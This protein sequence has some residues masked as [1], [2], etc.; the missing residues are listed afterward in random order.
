M[1]KII[2][3]TVLLL[4]SLLLLLGINTNV[5]ANINKLDYGVS[6]EMVDIYFNA[7]SYGEYSDTGYQILYSDNSDIAD[8]LEDYYYSYLDIMPEGIINVDL[9]IK[10]I[11][12]NDLIFPAFHKVTDK[13]ILLHFTYYEF[14]NPS[15]GHIIFYFDSTRIDYNGKIGT[16]AAS[17]WDMKIPKIEYSNT[18][19][20]P[21]TES[22]ELGNVTFSYKD[23]DLTVNIEIDGEY[24]IL[25]RKFKNSADMSIFDTVEAYYMNV[26]DTPQIIIS[27]AE[28]RYLYDILTFPDSVGYRPAFVPHSI[29]DLKTHKLTTQS[30][31]KT[32]VYVKQNKK[33][34]IISY[35]YIDEFVMDKV[36]SAEIRWT[37]REKVSWPASIIK[38][39]YTEWETHQNIFTDEDYLSYKNLTSSW[40]MYM[41]VW[42][43]IRGIYQ[44]TKTFNMKNIDR[45][46][47][48]KP[49]KEYNITRAEL[50]NVF[51]DKNKD[52]ELIK[53]D[54]RYNVF[55]FALQGGKSFMGTQTEFFPGTLPNIDPEDPRHY[56][57]I[58]LKYIT[59]GRLYSTKGDHMEIKIGQS[60]ETDPFEKEKPIITKAIPTIL[61][62]GGVIFVGLILY[63]NKAFRS[64]K[65]FIITIGLIAVFG[66]LIYL[67]YQ[68]FVIGKLVLSVVRLL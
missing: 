6:D 39:E 26:D 37:S 31:Y 65:A 15:D 1:K 3:F 57:I 45:V 56:Q 4:T 32:N 59:N 19:D 29:W 47:L 66:L 9:S 10:G 55:A 35:V 17:R 21:V 22:G 28:E 8:Y 11:D 54:S 18:E 51:L 68:Y 50:N 7:K 16:N 12:D 58:E 40:Q 43:I 14:M 62:V 13:Y 52:F 64:P 34:V 36:T 5:K 24:Y 30:S 25:R 38:G 23:L 27:H 46:N 53:D 49:Q 61:F 20:L 33:G 44:T 41:P 63:K 2:T 67:A 60:N 48:D 42:N